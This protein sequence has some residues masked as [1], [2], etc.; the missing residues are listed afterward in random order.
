LSGSNCTMKRC[1]YG[2]RAANVVC[3]TACD[4]LAGAHQTK[5]CLNQSLHHYSSQGTW[6]DRRIFSKRPG[7][8]SVQLGVVRTRCTSLWHVHNFRS[9]H[10][11][12]LPAAPKI[13]L[14]FQLEGAYRFLIAGGGAQFY[15]EHHSFKN[16]YTA[17]KVTINETKTK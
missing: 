17:T 2:E 8:G 4:H 7:R 16:V 6:L 10:V 15:F 3:R 14:P 13:R 11:I 5:T 12:Y 1:R 9:W